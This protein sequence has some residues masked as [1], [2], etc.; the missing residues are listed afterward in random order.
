MARGDAGRIRD[1]LGW[2]CLIADDGNTCACTWIASC[3]GRT[4]S[5]V[6]KRRT[7][8]IRAL[9]Y[10]PASHGWHSTSKVACAIA[11]RSRSRS[12]TLSA[13]N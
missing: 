13:S 7:A 5:T 6:R 3:S 9:V 8:R 2:T 4:K 1:A 10:L 11:K 12:F